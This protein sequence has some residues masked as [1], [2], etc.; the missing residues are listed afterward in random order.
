MYFA[1]ATWTGIADNLAGTPAIFA[2]HPKYD[3]AQGIQ[4]AGHADS[5]CI[6]A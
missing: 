5:Q 2:I 1:N 4:V 3:K 6:G